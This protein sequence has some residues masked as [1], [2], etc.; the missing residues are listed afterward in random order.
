MFILS[1][2]KFKIL[3]Y[4]HDSYHSPFYI[5]LACLRCKY[6]S[7]YSTWNHWNNIIH[8]M[9][10]LLRMLLRHCGSDSGRLGGVKIIQHEASQ[11]MLLPVRDASKVSTPHRCPGPLVPWLRYTRICLWWLLEK[12]HQASAGSTLEKFRQIFLPID[13]WVTLTHSGLLHL[14][15]L[16]CQNVPSP[17]A[18][19][20]SSNQAAHWGTM[21]PLVQGMMVSTIPRPGLWLVECH[22]YIPTLRPLPRTGRE[23]VAA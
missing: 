15:V 8:L 7:I 12:M 14:R 11:G 22:P 6:Q 9:A 2:C 5:M 19:G 3:S 4:L 17:Q 13:V 1:K 10:Q 18:R 16:R 21:A 20:G 23:A